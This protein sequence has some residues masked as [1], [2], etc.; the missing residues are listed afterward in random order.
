[1]DRRASPT[2]D[3]PTGE[4]ALL[5]PRGGMV[6]VYPNRLRRNV[7]LIRATYG[8]RIVAVVK[9]DGYG[10]GLTT[11]VRTLLAA[12]VGALA[13]G[14]AE[15]AACIEAAGTGARVI[16]LDPA[17]M[18]MSDQTPDVEWVVDLPRAVGLL[19]RRRIRPPVR[20]HVEVDFGLGRGGVPAGQAEDLVAALARR[21]GLC[22]A[23]LAAHLPADP[24]VHDVEEAVACLKRLHRH[25][26]NAMLHLGGSDVLRWSGRVT[27]AWLR[28]G[29]VLY[30]VRP[31]CTPAGDL[32]SLAPV[33]AWRARAFT[34]PPPAS[35][36]YGRFHPPEGTPVRVD[37]GY[38]DGLPPQAAGRWPLLVEGARYAI[39]QVFMLSSIAYPVGAGLA[40]GEAGEA[41]LSGRSEGAEVPVRQI[42]AALGVP[43]TAVLLI[44]RSPRRVATGSPADTA[45]R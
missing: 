45:E 44:P 30:G 40:V 25:C 6:S 12:G 24:R 23:G 14:T 4:E 36:G 37:I 13:V 43:T 35:V 16:V 38:A 9:G 42:A 33:W 41:L 39:Q 28:V 18:T 20:I 31:S 3:V 32:D 22:V 7:E 34:Y 17:G 21:P 15:E 10:L 19:S 11:C 26:P 27:G 1:M 5:P 29:R 2:T 8:K